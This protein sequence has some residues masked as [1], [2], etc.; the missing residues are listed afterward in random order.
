[1]YILRKNQFILR[2]KIVNNVYLIFQ[3][4]PQ[5]NFQ[6]GVADGHTGDHHSQKEERDGDKVTGSYSVKE[7]D[8]TVRTVHYTADKKNGFNAQVVRSGHASHPAV[9]G[10]GGGHDGGGG[11]GGGHG[12][13][14]KH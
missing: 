11:G 9:Y 2:K 1:M 13:G 4:H 7:A 8:G 14:G 5:Y 12:G 6:Y 10:G 3:A